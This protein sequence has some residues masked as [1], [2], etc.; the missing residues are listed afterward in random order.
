MVPCPFPK[1]YPSALRVDDE[2]YLKLAYNEAIAAWDEDEVPIGAVVVSPEGLV[3]ARAHN[4]VEGL[5]D[6]TAHA[7][8]LAITQAATAR[9]NWRLA[10]C[11]LYVTKEPCPMC[12]G[13][14]I[15][16]R[17]DRVVYAVPDPKMGGLGG[18]FD[19]NAVPTLNHHLRAE[20]GPLEPECKAL[21]Q[22]FF[23]HKRTVPDE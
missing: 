13:A 5:G 12:S 16:S 4:R 14:V 10:G 23:R 22:A 21:L 17:L 20:P 19:V 2:H 11:T 3:I 18:A 9:G 7:E 8:I 1:L 6:P 15:M